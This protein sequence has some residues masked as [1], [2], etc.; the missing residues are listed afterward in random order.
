M[1]T[2]T[3]PD[4]TEIDAGR[5]AT[6]SSAPSTSTQGS[7][8]SRERNSPAL[9]RHADE[10]THADHS[11]RSTALVRRI[12]RKSVANFTA[13]LAIMVRSGV[14]L[15]SALQ[16]LARQATRE[17]TKR[18]I[19]H[20]HQQVV[21]GNAFSAALGQYE[22]VFGSAYTASV[23]AGEASGKL[24]EVLDHLAKSLRAELRLKSTVRTLMAYPIV[25]TTVSL[26][27]TTALL[28]FVLPQ[29]AEIYDQYDAALP[30]IT[31]V[32]LSVG[33]SLRHHV[34]SILI[35]SLT[36]IAG[37]WWSYRVDAGR[38]VF[39]RILLNAPLL[40][41][42]VQHLTLG[43]VCRLLGLMLQSGVPL[44]DALKYARFSITNR[45]YAQLFRDLQEEVLEGRGISTTLIQCS[46][47]PG[48]MAE[49]LATG[50]QTGNLATVTRLVG[51]HME[52]EAEGKLREL[53]T[54]LEPAITIVLGVVVAIVVLSVMLPMLDLTR[55]AESSGQ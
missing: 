38:H 4:P 20:L 35:G 31:Q 34:W 45:V 10:M 1:P 54:F 24:P 51:Q 47:V 7:D 16:T 27:V 52:E 44:L 48:G 6:T 49:I 3:P 32:L 40:G 5:K 2:L 19:E 12:N 33:T 43:R 41:D 55:I 15:T 39:D 17:R 53:I 8:R 23:Q 29:F 18:L 13:Q 25:L 28:V 42:V 26:A 9:E 21:E 11:A 46:T 22:H 50:E 30:V 37:L 14:D 36:A